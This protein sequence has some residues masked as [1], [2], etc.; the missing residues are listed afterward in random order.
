MTAFSSRLDEGSIRPAERS[1]PG[2]SGQNAVP[3]L[4]R[5]FDRFFVDQACCEAWRRTSV[6]ESVFLCSPQSLA[7]W[8]CLPQL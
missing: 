1:N 6:D 7:H 8:R 3:V 5:F 2:L 4:M